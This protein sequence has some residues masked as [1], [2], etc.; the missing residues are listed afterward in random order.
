MWTRRFSALSLGLLVLSGAGARNVVLA[1]EEEAPESAVSSPP[2]E[3]DDP[4]TPGALGLEVNFVGTLE[5]IGAGRGREGLLDANFGIGDRIQLK[6]ERPYL[7]EGTVDEDFQ[8]GLGA[9]ELGVKWRFIDHDGLQIAVYPNYQFD[10][11]FT[12]KDEQGNPEQTPGRSAYLPVLVSENFGRDYTAAFNV[13][14]RR[15]LENRGD[16]VDLALGLGRAIGGSSRLLA[17]LFSERDDSLHNRQTDLRV[18][19]VIQLFPQHFE[20]A[21]YE[22][23]VFAS[24][25]HSIGETEDGEPALS[26]VVGTSFILKPHGSEDPARVRRGVHDAVS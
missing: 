19:Y 8:D 21:R 16:D 22:L 3:M 17:E 9:T 7:S 10:D 6:Y 18:G 1:E 2:M 23:P 4:G 14:Y 25:G 11:G 12:V 24:L 15:N 20:H 26:F 5:H 13:G